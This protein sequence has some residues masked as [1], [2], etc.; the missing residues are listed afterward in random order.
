MPASKFD[1]LDAGGK[2]TT[3]LLDAES[4][5]APVCHCEEAREAGDVAIQLES[6]SDVRR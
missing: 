5:K 2:T 6:M 1:A 4:A 3:G